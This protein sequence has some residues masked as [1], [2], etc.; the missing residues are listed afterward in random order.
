M[1]SPK[2]QVI[3][4]GVSVVISI[5][6]GKILDAEYFQKTVP[7]VP[8]FIKLTMNG[9]TIILK[10]T[11]A[12][13]NCEGPSTSMDMQATKALWSC[14]TNNGLQYTNVLPDEEK[15]ILTLYELKPWRNIKIQK[16]EHK[17]WKWVLGYKIY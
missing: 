10:L 16:I 2:L 3:P 6:T 1:T 9:K 15:A 4:W 7:Y 17:P 8:K 13:K 12:K 5:D 11:S 14:S